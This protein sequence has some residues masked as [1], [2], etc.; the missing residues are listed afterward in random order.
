VPRESVTHNRYSRNTP[1]GHVDHRTRGR[2]T[3]SGCRVPFTTD[4]A[5]C[6]RRTEYSQT[7]HR[8]NTFRSSTIHYK[9]TA[10]Y[11][12]Q[13]SYKS[14]TVRRARKY[15]CRK[16]F[17][18]EVCVNS[19][20][21]WTCSEYMHVEPACI[22]LWIFSFPVS[23]SALKPALNKPMQYLPCTFNRLR[24]VQLYM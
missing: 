8:S 1:H 11:L 3:A 4:I 19:N 18:F 23:Y 17:S 21:Y 24:T 7:S 20:P 6:V 22:M 2:K 12:L 5:T 9:W 16:I 15:E 14:M 10:P 13:Q